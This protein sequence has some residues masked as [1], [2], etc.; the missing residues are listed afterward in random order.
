VFL[1]YWRLTAR[2]CDWDNLSK[3][4]TDALNGLAWE[5][6]SQI[7]EAHVIKG[8]DRE[9]PRTCIR[10]EALGGLSPVDW[11]AAWEV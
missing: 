10:I 1:G 8:M 3:L 2:P 9:N 11:T 7:L 4:T 6:D 5:D